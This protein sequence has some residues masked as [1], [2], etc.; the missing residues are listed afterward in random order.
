MLDDLQQ[1]KDLDTSGMF[2]MIYHFPDN[3][4]EAI[5]IARNAIRGVKFHKILNIV[6][7][8]MGGSA[9]GGDLVRMLTLNRSLIPIIINRDYGMPAFVDEKT[10]VI[11][12]SYSGNTEETLAA[13]REAKRKNAKIIAITTGGKLKE[14]A[15]ADEVPVITIPKGLPP[16]AA[17]G[18]SFFPLLIVLEELGII[19]NNAYDFEETINFLKEIRETFIPEILEKDNEAKRLAKKIFGKIPVI[20][21]ISGLT[22]VIALRW[23]GQFN[24]NAKHP[25]VFNAFPELNHNEIMGFEGDEK[26]LKNLEIVILRSARENDRIVKRVEITAELIKNKVSGITEIL[27]KG[28]SPLCEMLYQIMYGDYVS[29]YLAILNKKDPIEIE[30]INILKERLKN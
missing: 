13:Y 18:Y 17:L 29:T 23:K 15:M 19:S 26:L 6:I 9:I 1:I 16:R 24:E 21:G 25:A 10:L 12:S 14:N 8:G 27:P 7:S 2:D 4:E 20:Y 30:S 3:C 11:A 22:D 28:N 5:N